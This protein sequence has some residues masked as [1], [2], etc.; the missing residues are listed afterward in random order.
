MKNFRTRLVALG[1][2]HEARGRLKRRWQPIASFV[3]LISL[4]RGDVARRYCIGQAFR[5]AVDR[6]NRNSAPEGVHSHPGRG[7][8]SKQPSGQQQPEQAMT[9]G[10]NSWRSMFENSTLAIARAELN[11]RF[12]ETNR[13]YN[14]LVGYSEEELRE[15]TLDDVV[16]EES[17][18]GSR[19]VYD[20]TP[21][22]PAA[23]LSN[24]NTLSP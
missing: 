14:N 3:A 6:I 12:V 7:F 18:C 1:A 20:T 11:G 9:A 16:Q 23:R 17:R 2:Q 4:P 5:I 22:R 10:S 19:G 15:I 24:R 21:H 13:A 8:V